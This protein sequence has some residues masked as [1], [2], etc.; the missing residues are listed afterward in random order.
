[1][2]AKAQNRVD[3]VIGIDVQGS[4]TYKITAYKLCYQ[5]E[6]DRLK[7][8]AIFNW[9]THNIKFDVA[10]SKTPNRQRATAEETFRRRSGTA[11]DYALLFA[12]MCKEVKLTVAV[13]EGYTH[14]WFYDKGDLMM[15]PHHAWNAVQINN[16]WEFA[17]AAFGAGYVELYKE[18]LRKNKQAEEIDSRQR[19]WEKYSSCFMQDAP[20]FRV[21]HLPA[22]PLWQL[23]EH[24]MPIEVFEK[25]TDAVEA[26]NAKYIFDIK[27]D[28]PELL[29]I[30]KMERKER[31]QHYAARVYKYNANYLAVLG[32]KE[33]IEGE[34]LIT[35]YNRRDNR[36][37][38][39]MEMLELAKTKFNKAQNYYKDQYKLYKPYYDELDKKSVFKNKECLY[40]TRK[41]RSLDL[42]NAGKCKRYADM[43]MNSASK[44]TSKITA[45]KERAKYYLPDSITRIETVGLMG[46][47]DSVLRKLVDSVNMRSEK[48]EQ[49]ANGFN[50]LEFEVIGRASENY[51]R[52]QQW[53]HN[54]KASDSIQRAELSLRKK[55]YDNN[56][57][58]LIAC[59]KAFKETRYGQTDSLLKYQLLNYDT[60]N[61]LQ[62]KLLKGYVQL[63]NLYKSNIKDIE[64]YKKYS[65][66]DTPLAGKYPV[67][68]QQYLYTIDRYCETLSSYAAFDAK[69]GR[70]YA[71]I[72]EMYENE[73]KTLD[74]IDLAENVRNATERREIIERKAF[75]EEECIRLQADMQNMIKETEKLIATE[76]SK[77]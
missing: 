57:T 63:M 49:L 21:T 52:L 38:A 15:L 3:T 5:V 4:A 56:D 30:A 68:V 40:Y 43:V 55:M 65:N 14:E 23:T 70:E 69:N 53:V 67:M 51:D 35:Q 28:N 45:A 50:A 31:V 47:G 72:A 22:D 1:M 41:L 73:M 71:A 32:H 16:K 77:Y 54:L 66:A 44:Y 27:R 12:E 75:D 19:F 34:W 59:N 39:F 29:N 9:I 6:L 36:K 61:K 33:S 37:Y 24:T 7:A 46:R 10:A 26:F 20:A 48:I 2:H 25:G 8:N 60:V 17:D 13:I 64:Q 11:D 58:L 42:Q 76:A 74:D 18:S 62:D